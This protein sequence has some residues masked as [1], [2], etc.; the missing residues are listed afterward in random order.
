[1]DLNLQDTMKVVVRG[2]LLALNEDT[3]NIGDISYQ[4]VSSTPEHSRTKKEEITPKK[5]I[6]QEIIKLRMEIKKKKQYNTKDQ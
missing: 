3:K 1:M 5:S 4:Q 2:E 6:W